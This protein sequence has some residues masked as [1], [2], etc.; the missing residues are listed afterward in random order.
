M[1]C[2][3]RA[4]K[5]V[6]ARTTHCRTM[7]CD[8]ARS[9]PRVWRLRLILGLACVVAWT[10]PARAQD[11][12]S[13]EREF[14]GNGAEI[15]VTVRDGSGEPISAPTMVRL[16]RDGTISSGQGATSQGRMSFIVTSLGEFTV[17][18]EA[19]GYPRT[20]KDVSV[21]AAGRT[22]VD[23]YL[24]PMPRSE[25]IVGVPGKP[26]LAPKAKEAFDRGLRALGADRLQDAQRFVSEAARL[27]PGHP[28]VLY[29][30][31]VLYLRQGRWEQAQ[32]ALE[33]ATQVDPNHAR[34]FAALGMAL[35]DQRKYEAA[36][37]PLEKSMQLDAGGVG[38][39]AYWALAK[40]YYQSARYEDAL[41]GAQVAQVEAKGK[42]P[43]IGLLVAQSLTAVGRYE[44]AANALREF[45]RDH[46]DRP[47]AV[48]ARR[49]LEALRTSGKIAPE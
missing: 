25:N 2:F 38:Y 49:W 12:G 41:K 40:A 46:G 7:R 6:K 3:T 28:D 16:I 39:E 37:A 45:L 34:A 24:R 21:R 32:T 47:E 9:R 29:A 43:E 13:K 23:I 1:P 14:F 35:A 36:I 19:A 5:Q 8:G 48:K 42:A 31:G 17:V 27:A 44:E 11:S 20:E 22:P 33:K 4:S 10:E 18:V 30:Q 26:L 15:A